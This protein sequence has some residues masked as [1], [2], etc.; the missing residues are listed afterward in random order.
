MTSFDIAMKAL[1]EG[2]HVR[3]DEW[4]AGSTMYANEDRQL[5]RTPSSGAACASDYNW[6]LDLSD[7]TATDWRLAETTSTRPQMQP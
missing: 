7:L 6:S 5:M 2:K 3:R 1:S 4:E